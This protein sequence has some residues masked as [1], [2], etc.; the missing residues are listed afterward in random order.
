MAQTGITNVP[1]SPAPHPYAFVQPLPEVSGQTF[2][3]GCIVQQT[4]G[5]LAGTGTGVLTSFWGVAVNNGQDLATD[6]AAKC[7][8]FRF[9][10]GPGH[11]FIGVLVG[12][13]GTAHMGGT[14]AVSQNSAG[15]AV[16][17]FGTGVSAS[18]SV[19]I[20]RPAPGWAIGDENALVYFIPLDAAISGA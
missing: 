7:A 2:P 9:Q 4:A 12:V 10:K 11:E 19:R 20:Q 1:M 6:G 3:H 5:S 15:I 8:A 18:S 14:A 17:T 13:L 16:L